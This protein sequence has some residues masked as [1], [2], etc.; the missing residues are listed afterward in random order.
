MQFEVTACSTVAHCP[1]C[2][3][4][5]TRVHSRR[6]RVLVDRAVGK[7]PVAV[8]AQDRRFRCENRRHGHWP[9]QASRARRARGRGTAEHKIGSRS[10]SCRLSGSAGAARELHTGEVLHGHDGG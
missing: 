9:S 8:R 4:G 10:A 5:S 3:T 1:V 7:R 2:G 6:R